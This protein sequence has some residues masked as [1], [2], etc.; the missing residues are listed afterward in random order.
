MYKARVY[1]IMIGAPSDIKEEVGIV[2]KVVNKT[3]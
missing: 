1:H 2:K 3:I